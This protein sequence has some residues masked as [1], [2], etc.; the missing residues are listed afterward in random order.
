MSPHGG[1]VGEGRRHSGPHTR[2]SCAK[3]ASSR[4]VICSTSFFKT[5]AHHVGSHQKLTLP[6]KRFSSLAL[7]VC[8]FFAYFS[9]LFSAA[10][11]FLPISS[12][13][14]HHQP[15]THAVLRGGAVL[16][17]SGHAASTRVA[18]LICAATSTWQTVRRVRTSWCVWR[19]ACVVLP[20]WAAVVCGRQRRGRQAQVAQTDNA[21]KTET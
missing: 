19:E 9:F 12:T 5:R 15:C 1:P 18:G 8:L 17:G 2:S 20:L 14:A 6:L 13:S 3:R 4:A 16:R 7:S 11:A 21:P 10:A